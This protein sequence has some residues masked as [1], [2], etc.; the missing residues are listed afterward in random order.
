MLVLLVPAAAFAFDTSRRPAQSEIR[1]AI[2]RPDV[3][4]DHGRES[5]IQALVLRSLR[6]E[7]RER[8][9]DAYDAEM[10]YDEAEQARGEGNVDADYLVE[11]L[12][13]E[14]YSDDFGGIGIGNRNADVTLAVIASRVAGQLRVYDARTM[15]VV[16]NEP[17]SRRSSA[18]LPTSV[19]LGGRDFYADI[20]LPFVQWAQIRRVAHAAARDAAEHV[21]TAVR[22]Q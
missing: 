21:T 7:L 10:T 9:F 1:I 16:A 14:A 6:S 2:L 11:V 20:A 13:G 5:S 22:G 19:G 8:G 15:D 3:A 17:I 12:G 4:Y 18:L